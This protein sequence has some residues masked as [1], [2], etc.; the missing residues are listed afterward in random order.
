MLVRRLA[1]GISPEAVSFAFSYP[2]EA[3]KDDVDLLLPLAP[4]DPWLFFLLLGGFIYADEKGH[5]VSV[6][7]IA[8]DDL[9]SSLYLHGPFRAEQTAM[10]VLAETGRLKEVS[11]QPLR[12]VGFDMF[13][14][15]NPAEELAQARR[16]EMIAPLHICLLAMMALHLQLMSSRLRM[17]C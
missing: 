17:A 15:V 16:P 6:T 1:A 12:D 5:V 11:F 8:L 3:L 4:S 14:W 7:A 10:D 2:I 9:T 13:A